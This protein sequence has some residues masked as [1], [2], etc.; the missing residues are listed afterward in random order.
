MRESIKTRQKKELREHVQVTKKKI[1][2]AVNKA[3]N[4]LKARGVA[5]R[6][7]MRENKIL[8]K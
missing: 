1:T 3:K 7:Q 8:F 2:V 6:K 4:T 5:A